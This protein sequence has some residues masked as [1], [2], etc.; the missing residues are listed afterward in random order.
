[1]LNIAQAAA[2]L[3]TALGRLDQPNAVGN[4]EKVVS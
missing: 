4:A 3:D 1:L 2:G